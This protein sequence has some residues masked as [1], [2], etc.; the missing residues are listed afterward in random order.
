M[1]RPIV[2]RR[3]ILRPILKLYKELV[4]LPPVVP[5]VLDLGGMTGGRFPFFKN[6]V[7]NGTGVG[8]S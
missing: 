7:F 2:G 4:I 6:R 8:F 5:W 1:R 3:S